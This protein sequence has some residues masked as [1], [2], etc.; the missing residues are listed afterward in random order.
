MYS[1]QIHTSHTTL[2]SSLAAAH[3]A[4]SS[5]ATS[6]GLL[7]M[8]NAAYGTTAARYNVVPQSQSLRTWLLRSCCWAD[9]HACVHLG[10]PTP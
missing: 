3:T 4:L 5:A 1:S 7:Y 9:D 6:Q 10:T 2:P 8:L